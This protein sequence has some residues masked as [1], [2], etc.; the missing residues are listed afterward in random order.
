MDIRKAHID[1]LELI[2]PLFDAYRQFYKQS[3]DLP[4]VRNFVK[5]RLTNND[6]IF[7]LAFANGKAVGFT[8]LYHTFSSVSMKPFYILNDLFVVDNYRGHGAATALLNASKTLAEANGQK[9][10]A[11]ETGIDNPA[12]KLYER[13]EWKKD[14]DY[15]HYFWTNKN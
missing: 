13:L 10:V 15:F 5:D 9:G 8:Q 12:Q 2:V 6:S 4:N 1:D 14:T 11:L 7:L 3:A